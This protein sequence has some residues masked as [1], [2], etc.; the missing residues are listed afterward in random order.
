VRRPH[1]SVG[2][3]MGVVLAAALGFAA[4]HA[5]TLVWASAVFT[6]A[7]AMLSAASLL[8]AASPSPSRWPWLGF[9]AFGWIYLLTTFWLW[10]TTNG[11][12]APP[13]LPKLLL[14]Y[15]TPKQSTASVVVVEEGYQGDIIWP[16]PI[17]PAPGQRVAYHHQYR[18]IGHTLTA[19]IFGLL[20]AALGRLFGPPVRPLPAPRG[21]AP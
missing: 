8:A 6:A 9:A 20:G 19:L 14:D 16:G 13:Y 15:A 17:T 18:R 21:D 12:T 5:A 7:V 3:L 4:L 11:V 1:F 2:A 10:P